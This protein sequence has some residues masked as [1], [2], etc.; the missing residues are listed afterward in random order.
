VSDKKFNCIATASFGLEAVV[1]SE[2]EALGIAE[3]RAEDRGVR[4]PGSPLDVARCNIGLRTADRVLIQL[5]EFAAMDFDAVY[6]GVHA[7]SWR[8]LLAAYPDVTV[9]ARSVKSRITATPA[10]QSVAK[11]AIVDALSGSRRG[12]PSERMP[13]TGPAYEVQIALRGDR[14]TVC[15][16]TT[17]AGL[18]KRGYRRET[19][20][21]PLRENLAAALVMLSRWDPSRPL[22]D[23]FCGSGTIP[24]EAAL[25]AA[26]IAP[27][28][29]RSFAAEKGP[30]IDARFWKQAR[31]E[32]KAGEKRDGEVR[33]TGSD[34]DSGVVQV[35]TRN[36]NAAGVADCV[37]ISRAPFSSFSPEGDY[38]CMICNPPY[39]ERMGDVEEV[40]KLYRDMGTRCRELPTWSVFV[41][42]AAEDFQRGF[43]AR[44]SRNRKLYN[45]N[46]R[47]WYY[48]Y[49]GPLPR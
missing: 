30:L 32:A 12:K 37:R 42:S 10:L 4:F 35:A 8:D 22:A 33:I 11:K 40:R 41:L 14:A 34:I 15:L 45:G 36:A 13:E 49:F 17:G 39:G 29:R 27:G 7:V 2:L 24:I 43:G 16:D 31:E 23:P 28:L 25:I 21:A 38:G 5:A 9:E 47:C 19:G 18:H 44:A 1:K 6:E 46:I 20:E 26:N 3:P 48:Q